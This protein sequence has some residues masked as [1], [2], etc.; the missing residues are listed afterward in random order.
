MMKIA[1]GVVLVLL[2]TTFHPSSILMNLLYL[3]GLWAVL[4]KSGVKGWW[5]LVPVA[6]VGSLVWTLMK[7]GSPSRCRRIYMERKEEVVR[8]W[9]EGQRGRLEELLNQNLEDLT[10]AYGRA[11]NESF[12]PAL[13]V[14]AEETSAM[15]LYLNVLEKMRSGVESRVGES[16]RLASELEKSLALPQQS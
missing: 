8:K 9:V 16:M 10:S 3:A 6:V 15:R 14:L 11:V 5:A 4:R 7:L 13:A 1:E 2:G 12:V